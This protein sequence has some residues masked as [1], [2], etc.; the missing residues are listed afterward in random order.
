MRKVYECMSGKIRAGG[1]DGRTDRTLGQK[2]AKVGETSASLAFVGKL[3]TVIVRGPSLFSSSVAYSL[4]LVSISGRLISDRFSS[5]VYVS[6]FSS[7]RYYLDHVT[8][9]LQLLLQY[10]YS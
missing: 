2:T 8:L 7:L 1:W 3:Y 6:L 5:H 4:C 9:F 10:Y